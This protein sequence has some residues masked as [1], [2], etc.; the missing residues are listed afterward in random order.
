MALS[1][2]AAV[3][4][5]DVN[6][7]ILKT[8]HVFLPKS[9]LEAFWNKKFVEAFNKGIKDTQLWALELWDARDEDTNKFEDMVGLDVDPAEVEEPV[10]KPSKPIFAMNTDEI[11][12]FFS[13]FMRER[14]RNTYFGPLKPRMVLLLLS[15]LHWIFTML[16]LRKYLTKTC[17]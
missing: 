15:Q 10:L 1:S 6:R 16:K 17:S 4:L 11:A 2:C 7:G 13:E 8:C 14:L 3:P 12:M 9:P 5:V